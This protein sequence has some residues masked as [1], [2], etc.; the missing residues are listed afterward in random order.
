MHP[1]VIPTNDDIF[2]RLWRWLADIV[3]S[4]HLIINQARRD[5]QDDGRED[6]PIISPHILL[7]FVNGMIL[8]VVEVDIIPI[9]PSVFYPTGTLDSTCE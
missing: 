5:E 1:Q 4:A 7:L 3:R 8:F 2:R 9:S 6:D